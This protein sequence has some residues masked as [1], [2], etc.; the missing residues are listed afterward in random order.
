MNQSGD[1]RRAAT[2]GGDTRARLRD[3]ALHPNR[4]MDADD[5]YRRNLKGVISAPA[6]L[7]WNIEKV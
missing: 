4:A 1:I 6:F 5:R 7:M 3:R 2:S